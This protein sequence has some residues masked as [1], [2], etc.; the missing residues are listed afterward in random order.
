VISLLTQQDYQMA[1]SYVNRDPLHNIYLIHGLQ[2]RG[3]AA[4]STTFWGA[5]KSGHLT[6]ILHVDDESRPRTGYL[7]ADNHKVLARLGKLAYQSGARKLVGKRSC[8]EPAT[9]DLGARVCVKTKRLHIY[10]ADPERLVRHYDYPVR[11]ATPNDIPSLVLLYREYEFAP[12]NRTDEEI[13]RIITQAMRHSGVYFICESEE[14]VVSAAR[15]F[16]QI[17]QA[18]MIGAAR[19]LPEFRGRGLY[20]SVRT[21]CF[22]HLFSQGKIGLGT[23]VD[24]NASM[25]RVLEKQGGSIMAEW[26]IVDLNTK[27]PLRRR[28]LPLRIRRWGLQ[29]R[30]HISRHQNGAVEML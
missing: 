23:F 5:F 15:L 4:N 7:A 21:A 17:D 24:T 9:V 19:T 27:P 25:H 10:R 6:G 11:M 13:E 28:I 16:P 26:L 29:I 1:L 2:T 14:H 3:L 12:K 8:I 18:G 20:L 30:D 22:E